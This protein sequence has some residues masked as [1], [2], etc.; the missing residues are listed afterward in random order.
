MP[1]ARSL[2]F[3]ATIVAVGSD[4]VGKRELGPRVVAAAARVVVD[5]EAQSRQLGELQ[6]AAA[7]GG[8]LV[9]GE[10]DAVR[11]GTKSEIDLSLADHGGLRDEDLTP[12]QRSTSWFNTWRLN[13]L[14]FNF[15]WFQVKL[16]TMTS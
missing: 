3:G 10:W 1:P 13:M 2:L 12:N 11:A 16:R 4:G 5:V 8:M 15:S 14:L 6:G 7:K 9:D